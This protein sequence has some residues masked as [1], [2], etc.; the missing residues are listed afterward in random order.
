MAIA[1]PSTP[2]LLRVPREAEP[3]AQDRSSAAA[4][5][6]NAPGARL[7]DGVQRARRLAAADRMGAP[8]RRR[9]RGDDGIRLPPAARAR[10]VALRRDAG[11][12]PR[13]A[14]ARP[15]CARSAA[16]AV[17]PRLSAA[18]I[19]AFQTRPGAGLGRISES[20]RE[21]RLASL[22]GCARAGGARRRLDPDP[23]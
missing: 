8:R 10:A 9:I 2:P 6:R 13:R 23:A 11:S 18:A 14:I 22:S 5:G 16:L 20:R 17:S 1:G 19:R 4:A 21:T 15:Q 3:L 7:D 12:A